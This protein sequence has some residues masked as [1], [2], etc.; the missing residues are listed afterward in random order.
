MIYRSFSIISNSQVD[1]DELYDT[2]VVL[3]PG[4]AVFILLTVEL[5]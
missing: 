5:P 3:A 2:M 4:G 1:D